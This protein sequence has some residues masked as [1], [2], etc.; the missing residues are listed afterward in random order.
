MAQKRVSTYS[1]S[2]SMEFSETLPCCLR[3]RLKHVDKKKKKKKERM[4]QMI[5]KRVKAKSM[6]LC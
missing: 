5:P 1:V 4:N 3:V 2:A 6:C